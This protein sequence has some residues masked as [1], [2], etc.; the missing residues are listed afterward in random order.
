MA[1]PVITNLPV[2]P[3]RQEPSTFS[4]R[5][6]ALLSSLALFVSDANTLGT[7]IETSAAQV[8]ADLVLNLAAKA[9]AEEMLALAPTI[10][11]YQDNALSYKTATEAAAALTLGYKNDVASAIVYQ[12]LASIAGSKAETA[13]DVFIYDTSTDSDGGAWRHR[14]QGTSYYNE[15]LNTATRGSTR[16]F[17]AVAVFVAET[18]KITIYDATDPSLPMWMVFTTS[19][20]TMIPASVTS[21]FAIDG[22]ISVGSNTA[23][24]GVSILEFIKDVGR[25]VVNTTTGYYKRTIAERNVS[26]FTTYSGE[27]PIVN[28]TVNDVT[29]TVEPNAP[30]DPATGLPVPTIR[31]GTAGGMSVLENDGTVTNFASSTY[32]QSTS[33]DPAYDLWQRANFG[34]SL[35]AGGSIYAYMASSWYLRLWDG[36]GNVVDDWA[37]GDVSEGAPVAGRLTEIFFD[38][39]GAKQHMS[40]GVAANCSSGWM[41]ALVKGAYLCD[42]D[43]TTLIES[44]ELIPNGDF[45][46][47]ISGATLVDANGSIVWDASGAM[48]LTATTGDV[49]AYWEVATV[50]GADYRIDVVGPSS[51]NIHLA[52]G[53]APNGQQ[54]LF[55]ATSAIKTFSFVGTGGVVYVTLR[56]ASLVTTLVDSISVRRVVADRSVANNGLAIVGSLPRAPVATGAELTAVSG[57]SG[58]SYLRSYAHGIGS[59]DF[60]ILVW[61]F[62]P[63]TSTQNIYNAVSADLSQSTPVMFLNSGQLAHSFTG[64]ASGTL[65]GMVAPVNQWNLL[66]ISRKNG[67]LSASVNAF[68]GYSIAETTDFSVS[69]PDALIGVNTLFTNV[70]DGSLALLR[71]SATAP[72]AAQ[73]AKIYRDELPMFRPN[74]ACT[75]F[76]TSDVP[77]ALG[78]DPVTGL[79]HVGTSAGRSIFDGLLRVGNTTTPVTTAIAAHDGLIVEQ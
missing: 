26:V 37:G 62:S 4:V 72:S 13:V 14:C 21:V 11:S 50:L 63:N 23:N 35:F 32:T 54:H 18:N 71:V 43:T 24:G 30:I 6:D 41:P 20:W 65:T 59:G 68:R 36:A 31:V 42:T 52:V 61:S 44:G 51:G 27:T 60:S 78:H 55:V 79:L 56:E 70:F 47:D 5:T 57:F 1:S 73:I 17:P 2:A 69:K 74:A 15:P 9:K 29:M 25:L 34:R 3:S 19:T 76:G 28:R 8:A 75:L 53:D 64:G 77:T 67:I 12:D 49:Y 46:S 7:Y 16:I 33:I 48:S 40:R 39:T 45:T 10:Q 22:V 58:A 66:E 38:P